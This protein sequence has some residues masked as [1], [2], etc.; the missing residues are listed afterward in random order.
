MKKISVNQQ[1]LRQIPKVDDVLHIPEIH[2]FLENVPRP[3]VVESIRQALAS[4]RQNI[5][6][7]NVHT[8]SFEHL[9]ESIRAQVVKRQERHLKRVING[10]GIIVH[11]NLGRSN[12]SQKAIEAVT[13]AAGAYS[14]L[15][16][17]LQAGERGSRYSHIEGV[18][19]DLLGCEAAL[20]VNNNAAAV[21][22][23][24]STLAKGKEAIISRGELVEIGGSFRVP[25][26]MQQGGCILRDVGATNRTHLRDYERAITE[27]TGLLLRVHTSNYRIVGFT[28]SVSLE[29]LKVLSLQAG[30][31]LV[32]DMGSGLLIKLTQPGLADEPT[33]QESLA[34]GVDVVTFSGDKLL[35][36]PQA[37]IIVG[38]KQY[39]EQIK[40][41][42][43][44]RA[45]RIDKMTLAALEVTLSHYRYQEDALQHIPTLQMIEVKRENLQKKAESLLEQFRKASLPASLVE[46]S[47]QVG[48]GALPIQQ[49]PTYC[50]C[51]ELLNVSPN[52]I[53]SRLR[54][55]TP[56]IIGR[57]VKDRYLLDVRT[58]DDSEFPTVVEQIRQMV[59][60]LPACLS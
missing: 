37:G 12:L 6:E 48:G 38:K 29:D 27:Q 4:L 49:L 55:G 5:L 23:V 20:V 53:A 57:I 44:N 43:L 46:A 59:V 40:Q 18:L 13:E 17:D 25:D 42:P 22:L 50:V 7:G 54:R 9:L 35:G 24:L 56:P 52:Q 30:I 2:S 11:T 1:L 8:F 16:Y 31:P 10:T 19:C 47:S 45:L 60:T 58:L 21:L 41:H 3:V 36:G 32:E 15:E 28:H 51:L 14:N 33:V 34:A 26:V 39:I